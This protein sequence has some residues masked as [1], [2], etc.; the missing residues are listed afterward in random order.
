M[1]KFYVQVMQIIA[2]E[3][4]ETKFDE[5]FMEEY[6]E[7]FYPYDTLED[8]AEHLGQLYARGVVDGYGVEFIEGYGPAQ[9][10]GISFAEVHQEQD[11]IPESSFVGT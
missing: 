9:E 6:R 7:S 8:H 1:K 10:M 4:D 2:V 3:L 11:I 5:A